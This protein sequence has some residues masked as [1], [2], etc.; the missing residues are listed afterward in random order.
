MKK[1]FARFQ[2]YLNSRGKMLEKG[3]VCDTGDNI[4]NTPTPKA[5]EDPRK[6]NKSLKKQPQVKEYLNQQGKM[7]EP[8]TAPVADY[9]GMD[10]KTPPGSDQ[11]YRAPGQNMGKNKSETGLGDMGDKKL[12]YTPDV[13]SGNSP[14]VPGGKSAGCWET[15]TKTEQF[16]EKT[17]NMTFSE[18]TQHMLE[19]NKFESDE[20]LPTVTSYTTGKFHPYP[21]EAVR[22][23]AAIA[24]KNDRILESLIYQMKERGMLDR[25]LKSLMEH[26]ETFDIL[27]N[28][29]EENEN[30]PRRCQFF[31]KSMN[32]R[33]VKFREAVGP[34]MSE[35]DDEEFSEPP[36][37]DEEDSLG[38]LDGEDTENDEEEMDDEDE[39]MDDEYND[40]EDDMDGDDEEM[41]D[42]DDMDGEDEEM[43]DEGD[44]D[45]EEIGMM[46]MGHKPRMGMGHRSRMGNRPGKKFAHNNMLDAMSRFE[47]MKNAMKSY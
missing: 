16:I 29:F 20:N 21:Q 2:E 43:D 27:S 40:D 42:E 23:V 30:G 35:L 33:I 12:A 14:H 10:P 32:N 46:N 37:G 15:K 24:D 44:M 45:D 39:E 26:N 18:F 13:K 47:P 17:K 31:A 3:T 6:K 36:E 28:L 25:I 41:D 22:Y 19:T 38:E 11:P 8:I 34:P 5:S 1:T 7:V 4:E 9:S